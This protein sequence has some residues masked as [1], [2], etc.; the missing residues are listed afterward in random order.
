MTG[1]RSY[2]TKIWRQPI[3]ST[4]DILV[5]SEAEQSIQGLGHRTLRDAKLDD[6][7]DGECGKVAAICGSIRE[8]LGPRAKCPAGRTPENL[9]LILHH[10]SGD[11]RPAKPQIV[12]A[13]RYSPKRLGRLSF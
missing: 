7:K 5:H 3:E 13:L 6:F 11:S 2:T 9:K 8:F 1:E 10:P 12:E 4:D